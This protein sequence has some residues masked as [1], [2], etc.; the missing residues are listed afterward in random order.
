MLVMHKT[1]MINISKILMIMT[2]L[3][4]GGCTTR[5]DIGEPRT[6]IEAAENVF[7][8]GVNAY[9]W[10]AT[11]DTMAFLPINSA[12]HQG[13]VILTDWKIS[14]YDENERTKVDIFIVGRELRAD[15]LNV[16]V[17]REELKDGNWSSI[18]P[19]ANASTQ[20]ISAILYQARILR[21]DNAPETIQ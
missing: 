11:L 14:P 15:A 9:L 4:V 5:T 2:L 20:V 1:S 3:L 17:H 10:R 19:R 21:R 13:G 18:E 7:E 12:D 8:I 16:T 6:N